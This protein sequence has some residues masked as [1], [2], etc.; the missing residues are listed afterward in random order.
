MLKVNDY[1]V[2]GSTG[3]CQITNIVK[4]EYSGNETEYYVLHPVFHNNMTIKTPVNN[5]NVYMRPIFTKDEVLSL[6][7]SLPDK[8]T[9]SI[10][11]GKQRTQRTVTF[12]AALKTGNNEDW[13]KVIKTIYLEKEAKSAINKKIPKTDE[14]IM[15]TAEKY[16]AEEF[17]IAL[18]ISP[19]EVVPYILEY[20]SNLEKQTAKNTAP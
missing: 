14:E 6:I 12:K 19:D 17:A 10:D 2:Y 20:I 16:L 15:N 4:E 18:N 13:V 9:F 5:P 1:V 7:A 11:D 8:E 3:V